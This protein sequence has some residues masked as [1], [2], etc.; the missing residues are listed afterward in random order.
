MISLTKRAAVLILIIAATASACS[1]DPAA[2]KR[3]YLESGNRYFDQKKYAEAIIEYRNAI[4]VDP[5]F[6]EARRRLAICY[7]Q[8]GDALNGVREQVRAADLLPDHV[9]VQIDAGNLLLLIGRFEDAKARAAKALEKEPKNVRAQVLMGNALAGLKDFDA[10]IDE[11]EEALRLD[12]EQ[13]STYATLG[14]IQMATG[15]R[16]AA[17]ETFTRALARDPSSLVAQLALANFY[18]T[19]GQLPE[20][21]KL[22]LKAA[23]TAPDDIR[24]N[25]AVANLFLSTNRVAQAEPY[26]QAITKID[27]SASSRLTLADYYIATGRTQD[28]VPLLKAMETDPAWSA[29]A[30]TRLAGIDI[31]NGKRDDAERRI[32]DLLKTHGSDTE[33]LLLKASILV[34]KKQVDEA[35]KAVDSAIAANP[36]SAQAQFARG[37]LA[38]LQR[39]QDDAI[40]AFSEALRRNPRAAEAQVELAKLHLA[41]GA[42]GTS[43]DL[44][45][46]AAKN[47]PS[48]VEAKL[49]LARGFLAQHDYVRSEAILREMVAANP[50]SAAAHTQ[51]GFVLAL[52]R[53]RDGATKEYEQALTLDPLYL[54]ATSGLISLDL[55]LK[56]QLQALKRVDARLAKTPDDSDALLLAGRTYFATGDRKTGETLMRRAIDTNPANLEAYESLGRLY[57]TSGRLAEAKKEFESLANRQERPVAALTVVGMLNEATG[58]TKDAQAA[59]EKA[60]QNDPSAAVAANNLAWIFV[61]SGENL[62]MA[63]QL[64]RTAKSRLPTR[65][66][67]SD[68]LGWVYYR[69][70]LLSLAISELE[71]SVKRDPSNPTYLFHVGMAYAKNGNR[72]RAKTALEGALKLRKDFDGAEEATKTLATL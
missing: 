51:L 17:Q 59:Y 31:R 71:D 21:E 6:G 36:R 41:K 27:K 34:S 22:L 39:R 70:G 19:V 32:D 7:L 9:D 68:T 69:K 23:S 45:G 63:L 43:V 62:D 24:V 42:I 15:N 10:A 52:K 66:E 5:S 61:D 56:N 11:V 20:A 37:K 30:G 26:L 2:A 12:P 28:A 16:Q 65:P 67:V 3:A 58:Q 40:N 60:L 14:T 1:K 38:V 25:R 13:I 47:D 57:I 29:R 72:E 8:T 33:A 44:A 64:A 54:E 48:S 50:K 4:K 35:V 46:Q 18:W 49:V 53:N 55:A